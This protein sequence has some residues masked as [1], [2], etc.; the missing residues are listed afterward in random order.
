MRKFL[1]NKQNELLH[2]APDFMAAELRGCE[3]QLSRGKRLHCACA[4]TI[5]PNLDVQFLFMDNDNPFEYREGIKELYWSQDNLSGQ[6][7]FL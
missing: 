3:R 2:D 6:N 5:K 4:A 1:K 7:Q